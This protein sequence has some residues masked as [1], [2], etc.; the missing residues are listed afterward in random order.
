MFINC[1]RIS[2]SR[3]QL[4]RAALH[5]DSVIE[6]KYEMQSLYGKKNDFNII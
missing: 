1:D 4:Y 3:I 6:P 2:T 5:T